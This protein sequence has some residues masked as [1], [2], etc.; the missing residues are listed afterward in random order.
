[1]HRENRCF[2]FALDPENYEL[3]PASPPENG[4]LPGKECLGVVVLVIIAVFHFFSYARRAVG[5]GGRKHP[6]TQRMP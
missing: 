5:M 4:L 3:S 6:C 1:M 2:P